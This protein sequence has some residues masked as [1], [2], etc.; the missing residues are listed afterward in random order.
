MS[1]VQWM[2]ASIAGAGLL[3]FVWEMYA[4]RTSPV[5]RVQAGRALRV[6]NSLDLPSMAVSEG[7][8]S[9]LATNATQDAPGGTRR[10]STRERVGDAA[11]PAVLTGAA[12]GWDWMTPDEHVLDAIGQWTHEDLTN[13][14]D[15][16]RTLE[17][18]QYKLSSSWFEIKLRGHV[19]E[20]NVY[21]QLGG[22]AGDRLGIPEA[23]NNPD[24]DLTFDGLGINVKVGADSSTI[25]EHLRVHPDIPVM[26]NEDMANLPDEA[27]HLDLSQPFDPD[28][29]A[30]HSIIVADGLSLSG[31]QDQMAD[32][33]GPH[34]ASYDWSD[35]LDQ[36]G[37]VL[38]IPVLGSAIRVVRSGIREGR[39][40]AEHGDSNRAI[41]NVAT[42]VAIVGG[43]VAIG[44]VIGAAIDVA[45]LGSSLGLFTMAG[46][47]LG[48]YLGNQSAKDQRLQPLTEA[49]TA[50]A[51]A[52]RRYSEAVE[53]QGNATKKTWETADLPWAMG[54]LGVARDRTRARLEL[55][56]ASAQRDLTAT[57]A[58]FG[59]A[60]DELMQ[61]TE[62]TVMTASLRP[63]Y[64]DHARR[65]TWIATARTHEQ[66]DPMTKLDLICATQHGDA[67]VARVL[68]QASAQRGLIVS[69]AVAAAANA[70]DE[71]VRARLATSEGLEERRESRKHEANVALHPDLEA[72]W[73]TNERVRDELIATGAKDRAWVDENYPKVERPVPP[74]PAPKR[75]DTALMETFLTLKNGT[76]EYEGPTGKS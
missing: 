15:L 37:D 7:V 40:A 75:I 11:V 25:A 41:K 21:D 39:L 28:V 29:L 35:W 5:G 31:I 23:S 48:G 3:W 68:S 34:L 52:L 13:G 24:T 70:T 14:F 47:A 56:L 58:E 12:I 4:R 59:R 62:T 63:A 19:A 27:I 17:D 36:A 50:S 76:W 74:G 51:M 60:V 45:L 72:L 38:P 54:S 22:W 44:G 1:A 8:L 64:T 2:L 10:D 57:R 9:N 65:R 53:F 49:Q 73:A 6:A 16:W 18:N 67:K 66:A 20:Q 30:G 46:S 26:V 61:E 32:A 43:G 33:I 55:V 69:A 71:M 42:D